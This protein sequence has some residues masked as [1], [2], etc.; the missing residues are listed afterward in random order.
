MY[1]FNIKLYTKIMLSNRD[2]QGRS[3]INLCC[4]T[5]LYICIS[6]LGCSSKGC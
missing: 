1:T 2:L 5:S 4:V 3:T 6:I